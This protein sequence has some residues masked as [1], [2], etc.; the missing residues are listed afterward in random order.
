MGLTA[1]CPM[2]I[3][4]AFKLKK[5]EKKQRI[6]LGSG[7]RALDREPSETPVRHVARRGTLKKKKEPITSRDLG[8][9]TASTQHTIWTAR[10]SNLTVEMR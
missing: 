7:I 6:G 1:T 4:Q 2:T 5:K 8:R 3:G 10:P 9:W